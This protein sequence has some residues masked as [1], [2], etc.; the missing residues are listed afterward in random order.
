MIRDLDYYFTHSFYHGSKG[1]CCDFANKI[2]DK[3]DIKYELHYDAEKDRH[4]VTFLKNQHI[5]RVKP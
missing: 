1:Q 3:F 4:F 2:C 5:R